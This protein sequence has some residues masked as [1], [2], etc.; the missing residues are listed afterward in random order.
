[1]MDRAPSLV[2]CMLHMH[3]AMKNA[4]V[5]LK[6]GLKKYK[7]FEYVVNSFKDL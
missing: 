1:M 2:T 6:N 3:A 7:C 5:V 4:C